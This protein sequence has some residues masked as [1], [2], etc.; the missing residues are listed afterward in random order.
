M[1]ASRDTVQKCASV[2]LRHM[3]RE[4]ALALLRDLERAAGNRSFEETVRAITNGGS[5]EEGAAKSAGYGPTARRP[6]SPVQA[7]DP[8]L[9]SGGRV[10][11]RWMGRSAAPAHRLDP[12][13][14]YMG[15]HEAN[16][17]L[18]GRSSSAAA[19]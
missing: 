5:H 3:P 18:N 17:F 16:H 13:L 11:A 1:V 2:I 7:G 6:A 10:R 8:D 14:V 12:K 19:K 15:F 4:R 9:L